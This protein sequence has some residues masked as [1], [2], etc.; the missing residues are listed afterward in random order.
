MRIMRILAAALL[1]LAATVPAPAWAQADLA[2]RIHDWVMGE[3]RQY[4]SLNEPKVMAV[5]ITWRDENNKVSVENVFILYT[6]IAS[7]GPVF[8]ETLKRKSLHN[9]KSWRKSESIDCD[10]TMLDENGQNVLR[11]PE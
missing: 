8:A 3:V 5:C 1:S 7:D 11:L 2:D 6:G 4:E 9:C 10:C